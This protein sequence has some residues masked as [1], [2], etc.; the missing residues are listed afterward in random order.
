M[1][2]ESAARARVL[3]Q[4]SDPIV[5]L[6]IDHPTRV[7]IDGPDAAGKTTLADDLAARIDAPGLRVI[8]AGIDGFHR[9]REQRHA[10]YG[11]TAEAFYRDSFD[12][13]Q[14]RSQLLEPLGEAGSR[15]YRVAVFDHRRDA[16]VHAPEQ[17]ARADDILLFDGIFLLRPELTDCWD[18]RIFVSVDFEVTIRRAVARDQKLFGSAEQVRRRYQEKYV[19]GQRLYFAEVQPQSLADAIVHNDDPRAPSCTIRHA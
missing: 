5:A 18:Y 4:L 7:A 10:R 1:A 6:R 12:Y 19:P 15:R 16:R 8:R 17:T 14:L 9:S 3:D 2:H 11:D 13:P